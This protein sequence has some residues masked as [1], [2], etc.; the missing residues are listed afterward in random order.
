MT[1]LVMVDDHF[2]YMDPEERYRSGEFAD[3][4][5]AIARCR[6]IVD[7]YL[8]ATLKAAKEGTMTAAEL[9][10]SYTSFGEDPFVVTTAGEAP[11]GFRAW[12]YARAQCE[13]QCGGVIPEPPKKGAENVGL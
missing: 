9:W 7:D 1:Y 3:A 5:E 10:D 2:N 13:F 11:V 12:D 4:D 6:K 8:V